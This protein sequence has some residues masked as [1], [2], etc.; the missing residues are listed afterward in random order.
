MIKFLDLHAQYSLIKNEIDDAITS[1]INESAF[2][3]GK[4]VKQFEE[5]FSEYQQ[6]Q[7]CVGVGNGTDA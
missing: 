7:Y 4:Y 5:N 6:A 3:G 2:I 1:V